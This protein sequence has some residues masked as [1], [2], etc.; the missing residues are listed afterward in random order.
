MD[1]STSVENIFIAEYMPRAAEFCTKV[2]LYG[3]YLCCNSQNS[4]NDIE[5]MAR[6]L[7]LAPPDVLAAYTY[8]QE[9]GLV[10]I[11]KT[12]P[13]EVRYLPIRHA[14][15]YKKYK[16]SKFADFNAQ[17]QEILSARMIS[18]NEFHEYYNA[19]EA[20]RFEPEALLMIA[21]YCAN[22]KGPGINYPYILAVARSWAGEGVTTVARVEERLLQYDAVA[23]D[24]ANVLKALKVRKAPD[25]DDRQLYIKW[26][27]NMGFDL[28]AV[29]FAAEGLGGKGG[30]ERLDRK[31]TRYY[32]SK[33]QTREEMAGFEKNRDILYALARGIGRALGVYYDNPDYFAE[34]YIT[35]WLRKGYDEQSLLL[36][37][38]A[39]FK[40]GIKTPDGMNGLVNKFYEKGLV[41]YDALTAHIDLQKA[42]D[43]QIRAVL[44][45]AGI[46]RTAV[47]SRDRDA[48]R[49]WTYSWKLPEPL[50]LYAAELSKAA[51]APVAYMNKILSDWYA[52]GITTAEQARSATPQKPAPG[53][54]PLDYTRKYTGE[55]LNALFD[56][57]D[58]LEF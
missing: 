23:A 21:K 26:T 51:A 31:L 49:T 6:A 48:Y 1:T 15:A 36:I 41:G 45:A 50:I 20:L 9:L 47:S 5:L 27:G 7:D 39:C 10:Q 37:A 38:D 30:A 40:R 17:I 28:P 16:P 33:L 11:I 35:E 19:I 57:I 24:M 4:D 46:E 29:L 43:A 14:P 56:N 25:V 58:D 53:G 22:L 2:Y 12:S 18:P 8:W 55:E 13:P 32:E 3:L 34:T 44:A 54:A 42:A 52:R